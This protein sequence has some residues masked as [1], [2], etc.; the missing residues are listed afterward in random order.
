MR[1]A[2]VCGE[3]ERKRKGLRGKR[4]R[5]RYRRDKRERNVHV[6]QHDDVD[7]S[8]RYARRKMDRRQTRQRDGD[9]KEVCES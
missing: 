6:F 7:A 2:A 1:N 8:R 5:A 4:E 3:K 9:K